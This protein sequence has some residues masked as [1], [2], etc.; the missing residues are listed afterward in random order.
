MRQKVLEE[1]TLYP[2][3]TTHIPTERKKGVKGNI[4]IKGDQAPFLS[5]SS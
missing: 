1:D 4:Q 2:A 5:T 3:L